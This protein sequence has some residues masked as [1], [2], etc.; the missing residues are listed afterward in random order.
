MT[1]KWV[2]EPY[3][4]HMVKIKYGGSFFVLIRVNSAGAIELSGASSFDSA[5]DA[6]EV[7]GAVID[8]I[9]KIDG[10]GK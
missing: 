7:L 5:A 6:I 8:N 10:L 4:S 3:T 9:K 1:I 2:S